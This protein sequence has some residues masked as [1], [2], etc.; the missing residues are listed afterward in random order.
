MPSLLSL[1]LSLLVNIR[2]FHYNFL[3]ATEISYRIGAVLLDDSD[4]TIRCYFI[5][6]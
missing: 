1:G 5:G 6:R 3:R 2:Q 4:K